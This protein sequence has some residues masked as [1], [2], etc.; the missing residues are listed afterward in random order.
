MR[1]GD[2]QVDFRIRMRALG[3]IQLVLRIQQVEQAALA[4]V[5]LLPMRLAVRHVMQVRDLGRLVG[6]GPLDQATKALYVVLGACGLKL[7]SSRTKTRRWRAARPNLC[8]TPPLTACR[9]AP[10]PV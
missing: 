3:G 1:A 8:L 7:A 6:P 4:D 5:E 10:G 2:A 9:F